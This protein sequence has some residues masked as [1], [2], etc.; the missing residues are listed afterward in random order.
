MVRFLTWNLAK[1]KT[2]LI[3]QVL[4]EL[5]LENQID[6]IVLQEA[7][8][9]FVNTALHLDYDELPYP[10]G[11]PGSGVRVFLRRGMFVHNFVYYTPW[12][13]LVCV[14][15]RLLNGNQYF[16]LAAVHLHSKVN[17]TARQQQWKNHALLRRLQDWE[18]RTT[19][20]TSTV[21]VGDLNA[22][23]YEADLLDPYLLRGQS[24]QAL[25]HHLAPYPL[26]ASL[27]KENL[28][29]WYNPMWNLLG[30]V[31]AH[32]GTERPTG[33]YFRHTEDETTHWN[34]LDGFLVR[35]GL[36][37]L[38]LHKELSIVQRTISTAFI[39]PFILRSDETLLNEDLSDHLPVK[40]TITL[41]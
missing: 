19:N 32:T 35:P 31:D 23:P 14:E 9:L 27:S 40:F 7:T 34:L 33:T 26:R 12:R 13:K 21:L 39:K 16:N 11:K 22:A 1:K 29:F 15:L 37:R 18:K 25:I 3:E 2:P 4:R 28:N 5:A 8:G 10:N 38:V 17:N 20:P 30:D 36:M 41:T 6:I 24:S